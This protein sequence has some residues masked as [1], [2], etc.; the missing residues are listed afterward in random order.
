VK[1]ES[2]L[3]FG[4][5]NNQLTLIKSAKKRGYFTVVIDPDENAPGKMFAD[6]FRR[7]GPK[8]F[9]GT[10]GVVEEYSV[11][12]IVTAQME[13]PLY[14]MSRI[15]EKYGFIFPSVEQV[16][17]ARNKYLMK[18]SFLENEVPC[19][20]GKRMD[21]SEPIT[22]ESICGLEFPLVIKPTDA[23]SSRG[24][25][26]VEN[27]N[28]LKKFEQ[29]ARNFS[30][31]NSV[32]I[33]EFIS[34][35]EFSVESITFNGIT[36]IIQYTEKIIT[37]YPYTVEMGHIQPAVLVENEM[38]QIDKVVIK[39]IAA[40]GINN[41]ASHTELMMTSKGPVIIEIG[42]RLG[43]D[44]ISSYLTLN[45]T[46]VNMDA[47]ASDVAMGR[48]PDIQKKTGKSSGIFYFHLGEKNRII[49][50]NSERI[51]KI[52]ELIH[53]GIQIGEG[54]IIPPLTDSSKRSGFFIITAESREELLTI[55]DSVE[56]K[57]KSAFK[58]EP[59]YEKI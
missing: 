57:I 1:K 29:D 58:V 55:R 42:A 48:L 22:E 56:D 41:C 52:Q 3:I 35:K 10:C 59:A 8:D 47:A 13:N 18:L 51:K 14:L 11:R 50:I 38:E 31:D 12:G 37:G 30:S 16:T 28:E 20:F 5:G 9:E 19:A 40:L 7:I 44:Y 54:D 33:E 45:S 25:A 15:A 24:V 27:F 6:A 53:Y 4:G 17:K 46:G 43:G 2:I 36:H 23:F 21:A 49:K 39:A 26:K 32:I 34:G